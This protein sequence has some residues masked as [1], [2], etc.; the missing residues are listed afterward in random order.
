MSVIEHSKPSIGKEEKESVL[1]V[2]KSG[3]LAE[4]EVV[5][6][7]EQELSDYIGSKGAVATGTGTQA[8]HLSLVAL[9]IGKGSE[10]IVPS[11]VCRS[12]L[13]A[14]FYSGARPVVCDVNEQDYNISFTQAKKKI[15]RKTKA[16]IVPHM[17]GCP[18]EVDKFKD[19]G[20][21]VIEDCA[22]SVG[23]Q[24]KGRRLGS[25]GD[26]AV[27]SFEGTKYIVAGEGGMV[28]ANSQLL[29]NK[30]RALK[31]PDSLGHKIKH[32]YRMTNLQA[33]VGR[34][35]LL[36][37]ASFIRKRK[38]IA[39]AYSSYFLGLPL[40]LP[41]VPRE[42]KHI[43][44]RYVVRMRQDTAAFM[45][46]CYRKGVKVKQPVKPLSLHGYLGLPGDD[47]PNTEHIMRSAVSIPIYPSLTSKQIKHIVR[48]VKSVI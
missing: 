44:H 22:H 35:Q 17:F 45:E 10:V 12:L 38:A 24:Y 28:V 15:S 29:L 33:A 26:L 42:G 3:F 11:Y 4:G 43:F 46:R 5:R 32:T 31:E 47:F 6:K 34:E 36:K 16:V 23:A 1:K 30:I 41:S 18:A 20:I 21:F 7:F 8:L 27:F 2:L 40:D 19:L 9:G 48:V 14:V 13:N 37:L 25:W 39:D